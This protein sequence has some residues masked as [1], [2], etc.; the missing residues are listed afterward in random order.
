MVWVVR[1][2]IRVGDGS[3]FHTY[4]PGEPK[5][6]KHKVWT[7]NPAKAVVFDT[8]GDAKAHALGLMLADAGDNV[9]DIWVE[10]LTNTAE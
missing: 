3:I 5:P 8:E 6:G 9:V 4:W 7:G 2:T 10:P 1:A